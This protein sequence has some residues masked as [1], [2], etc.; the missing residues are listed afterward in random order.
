MPKL[1]L[2]TLIFSAVG[3]A[4]LSFEVVLTRVFAVI[5]NQD[6]V[7]L[8]VSFAILGIGLGAALSPF[9][10]GK[11]RERF[12]VHVLAGFALIFPLDLFLILIIPSSQ[13]MGLWL[14]HGIATLP[15]FIVMGAIAAFIYT[16]MP[17]KSGILYVC[18]LGGAGLGTLL[19][20]PGMDLL[21][22]VKYP[23]LLSV[24]VMG[25]GLAAEFLQERKIR[26]RMSVLAVVTACIVAAALFPGTQRFLDKA[27]VGRAVH[28]KTLFSHLKREGT[29]IEKTLWNSVSRL[30]LVSARNYPCKFIYIDGSVPATMF[31]FNT[32]RD[33]MTRYLKHFIC[34]APFTY[35]AFSNVL[36]IGCGAGLDCLLGRIA[37][38][39]KITA[40]EIN[41]DMI[42][43]VREH[44]DYNGN[45]LDMP[46]VTVAV[47]EGRSFTRALKERYD[48]ILFLLALG[49]VTET[50]GR[51]LA[52]NYL[53]TV[54]AYRDYY[55]RLNPGGRIA[56][57]CSAPHHVFRHL[58][59][60]AA[61]LKEQGIDLPDAVRRTALLSY[62]DAA[63]RYLL[64]LH[65]DMPDTAGCAKLKSFAD[66]TRCTA[67]FIPFVFEADPDLRGMARG[68]MSREDFSKKLPQD[69]DISPVRDNKPFH[70]HFYKGV[71]SGLVLLLCIAMAAL[72]AILLLA[73]FLTGR[74]TEKGRFMGWEIYFSLLGAGFM[75]AE[76]VFIRRTMLYIG[77][78]ALSLSLV[79][80]SI[81][82]GA[83]AGGFFSQKLMASKGLSHLRNVL[84][85]LAVVLAVYLYLIPPVMDLF[86]GRH[87]IVR[88]GMAFVLLFIPSFL[89]GI[90]FPWGMALVSARFRGAAAWMWGLNGVA[91][92]AGSVLA[93]VLS[94]VYGMNTAM[95]TAAVCYA[96]AGLWIFSR[97][98]Q[99]PS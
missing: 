67:E 32:N 98:V 49:N 97:P 43:L 20:I 38:A 63:Y 37:G 85:V 92:V 42:D 31:R 65:R 91:S 40:V 21:G 74:K 34:Y 84:I 16:V 7:F 95:W 62:P 90:P 86:L 45:V 36:S 2:L 54:E 35:G 69:T 99:E 57:V 28:G 72:I 80:F 11:N 75:I 73:F 56:V 83:G 58:M 10:M 82:A 51:V 79:L 94:L 39:E 41:R 55:A 12:P 59:T 18:D 23:L 50:G 70:N 46:G 30:D 25:V 33:H 89:L 71:P 81:L 3:F 88:G 27:V 29:R 22:P 78:P 96:L 15:P 24:A 9:I 8:A 66:S 87:I 61:M 26:A 17:E 13:S 53:V 44:K 4:S 76:V 19:A 52:E 93:T 68:A 1:S 5:L 6:F 48:L 14:L 77:Y 47:D 60:W 64:I